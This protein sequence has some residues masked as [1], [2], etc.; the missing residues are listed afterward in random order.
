[1]SALGNLI[2][3]VIGNGGREHALVWLASRSPL[4]GKILGWGPN[5][6]ILSES[7]YQSLGDKMP[8]FAGIIAAAKKHG[9]NLVLIGPEAPLVEGLADALREAG[10]PTFGPSAAAAQ[11]EG[12]KCFA[13]QVME[14]ARVPTAPAVRF[15]RE[16][17][18]PGYSAL[19]YVLGHP[20]PMVVKAD[21]LAAGKGAMVC[22]SFLEAADAICRCFA[23]DEF[24]GAGHTLL[25]E[26][27][28]EGHPN[29]PRAEFSV[30]ALVDQPGNIIMMPAA[31]DY[32][33]VN[34]GDKGLNTGG[35][36]AFS[37]IPWLTEDMMAQVGET[38]F[39]P[40]IAQMI[41]RGTPFSGVLYAG[42]MWTAEGPKVVEFNVRFGDPELQ[43]LAMRLDIDLIPV[44]KAI[45]DGESI[46]GTTL[47]WKSDA[48]CCLVLASQGYPGSYRKG[49][50]I[51][52]LGDLPVG[53]NLKVFHAGTMRDDEQ[54]R[55]NG[56][57]V[58]NLTCCARTLIEAATVAQARALKISFGDADKP[59]AG[60][61]FR[62]D[63][64]LGVPTSIG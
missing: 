18:N 11:L 30:L 25:V 15:V 57:R 49:L 5:V 2:V 28:L 47:S 8:D 35:M 13:K 40:T 23:R 17:R 7:K 62:K 56:G 58:L 27:F 60:L 59:G 61:H 26:R 33:P 34:D 9:V 22:H 46:K 53:P 38:V 41:Q 36:G 20:I 42:L 51:Y 55:T 48:A 19:T 50:G 32:K 1:M 54:I 14:D 31:Q 52:G 44:M 12:S 43:P 64:G 39:A 16:G 45:A 29:L 3:L 37:P 10:V 6:G 24:G 21:G 63:V 4:V